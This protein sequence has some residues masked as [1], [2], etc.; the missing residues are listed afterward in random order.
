VEVDSQE[1]VANLS[2]LPD[3]ELQ[4]IASSTTEDYRQEAISFARDEL[5]R[6]GIQVEPAI[7]PH[8]LSR[9]SRP[10]LTAAS[11][12]LVVKLVAIAA[13]ALGLMMWSRVYLRTHQVPA[14]VPFPVLALGWWG[15]VYLDRN[16]YP[17]KGE[18]SA[19]QKVQSAVHVF[20]ATLLTVAAVVYFL[21]GYGQ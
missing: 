3:A 6:R 12:I 14:N 1:L 21:K 9:D 10:P 17:G 4:T 8:E 15:V 11:A 2:S 16:V 18:L 13:A 5:R 19:S 7:R 20:I